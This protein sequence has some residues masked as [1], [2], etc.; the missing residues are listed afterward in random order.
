MLTKSD[1]FRLTEVK[2]DRCM[3]TALALLNDGPV[4]FKYVSS[5]NLQ[6]IT[7]QWYANDSSFSVV[8]LNY[9]KTNG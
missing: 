8:K 1:E 7:H 3:N 2:R 4:L 9:D 5:W 6:Y